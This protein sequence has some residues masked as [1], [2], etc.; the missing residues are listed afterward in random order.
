MASSSQSIEG[1]SRQEHNAKQWSKL[2][3]CSKSL[4]ID[5]IGADIGPLPPPDPSKVE[6]RMTGLE[7]LSSLR[8]VPDVV[9]PP[10]FNVLDFDKYIG[11]QTSHPF[12]HLHSQNV[13]P[14]GR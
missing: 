10:K 5:D 4:Q 9:M 11:I 3:H 12:G 14:H 13:H 8:L 1:V 7:D 2:I 6:G